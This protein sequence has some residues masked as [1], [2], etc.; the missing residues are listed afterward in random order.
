[1]SAQQIALKAIALKAWDRFQKTSDTIQNRSEK[2][3]AHL[4]PHLKPKSET[5]FLPAALEII[6]TPASPAGRIIAG[7]LIAFFVI[8]LLWASIGSVDIIATAS[9]KIVPTGR[10][11]IIQPF[12]TGVVRAIHVQDGQQVKAGEVLIEIDSTISEAERDRLQKEYMTSALDAARLHASLGMSDNPEDDFVAPENAPPE[13][14]ILQKSL[15]VSQVAEIRAKLS[16]LDHQ[17]TQHEGNLAAVQSN[18][19]KIT[20]ALPLL[21]L[22]AEGKKTIADKGVGS[23][24]DAYAIQQNLVEHQQELKVQE[25]RL[26]EATAEVASLKDQRAQTEAEY[27]RKNLNDLTQAE[28]KASSL[29]EQLIQA[30]EKYRLQTLTAPVDG[31]VQQLAVHT[32]GGVVTP[33]QALLSIVPADSHLEIE[34]MVSNRDIGFVHE[35]QD[36]MVK[37]DTFN[38][39]RYGLLHGKVISVSQD[40]ITRD[41]PVDKA[42]NKQQAGSESDTSEPKG[43][44]LVY[45]A[46]VSLDKT[47]MEID[48]RMVNLTPGMAVTVEVKTGS[49]HIIGYLLSPLSRASH[50]ALRER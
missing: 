39:T 20:Y 5:E 32:E 48:D 22:Q 40:A 18:I 17:I 35:G 37:I 6:E 30:S 33:A 38:Y 2:L 8:A 11:K 24:L 31:T 21:K 7:T 50:E 41:K 14:L 43:Q 10:T 16:G 13:Q 25:G 3:W 34:A 45:A 46:R 49:R 12:E 27:R 1:M 29:H 9:G 23:K 36:V 42:D 26:Q 4:E 19:D 47:Q 15:L 28:Q 44:E